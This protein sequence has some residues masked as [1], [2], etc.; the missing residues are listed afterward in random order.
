MPT[1]FVLHAMGRSFPSMVS[2]PWAT[3]YS[4]NDVAF[5]PSSNK[6][7]F[8]EALKRV[9]VHTTYYKDKILKVN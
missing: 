9:Q 4:T 6:R 3:P 5:Y 2:E 7:R 1:I 8:P